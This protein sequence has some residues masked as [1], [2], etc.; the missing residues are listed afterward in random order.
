VK[1][2]FAGGHILST[3]GDALIEVIVS[4]HPLLREGNQKTISQ[5][6]GHLLSPL[7]PKEENSKPLGLQA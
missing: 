1:N 3:A 6:T 7:F 2:I 5:F 4:F